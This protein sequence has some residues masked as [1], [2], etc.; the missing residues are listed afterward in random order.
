MSPSS[1]DAGTY[2]SLQLVRPGEALAAEQPVAHKRPLSRV[3]PQVRFEMCCF[4]F[5]GSSLDVED[6]QFGHRH[7]LHRRAVARGDLV[8]SSAAICVWYC[9]KSV[10][11]STKPLC[12]WKRWG[13]REDV[14]VTWF[15]CWRLHH[16]MSSPVFGDNCLCCWCTRPEGPV[17]KLV[18]AGAMGVGAA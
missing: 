18:M 4:F 7:L 13:P 9:A 11:P 3:P 8:C 17:T 6:W 2:V 15:P 16:G 10:C 12:S 1:M 14:W 5:P